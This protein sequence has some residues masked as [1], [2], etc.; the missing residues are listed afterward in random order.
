MILTRDGI[1]YRIA[2][3]LPEGG[4][5]CVSDDATT[6]LRARLP[7][8]EL[9]EVRIYSDFTPEVE[10]FANLRA[11]LDNYQ[12]PAAQL[13]QPSGATMFYQL[14]GDS[15]GT[16]AH[17]WPLAPGWFKVNL[18]PDELWAG[19]LQGEQLAALLAALPGGNMNEFLFESGGQLYRTYL[20]PW[21]PG[22]DHAA[23][24]Q[25][26]FPA[27]Q[28]TFAGR[29]EL[30]PTA[31]AGETSTG[32]L[33]LVYLAGGD[34]WLL[35][36]GGVALQLTLS[37]DVGKVW[38]SPDGQSVIYSLY[39]P[40]GSTELWATDPASSQ[41]NLLAGGPDLA[42]DLQFLALSDVGSLLAFNRFL[43][44]YNAEL[45][46]AA[47]DGSGA[48]Q[49]VSLEDL[50]GIL[51]E[52]EL[53]EPLGV[54]PAGVTWVPGTTTLTYDAYPIFD[55][56]YIYIQKQVWV[57]DAASGA[58]AEMFP[59]GEG[60]QVSYSPDGRQLALTTPERLSVMNVEGRL[61][62]EPDLPY[63][64]VGM[65]EYYFSPQPVWAADSSRF[66]LAV[67]QGD[68]L[69]GSTDIWQVA[70][71]GDATA[72]LG[73]FS[74]FVASFNF[75]PDLKRVAFWQGSDQSLIQELH[76]AT[77][78]GSEEQVY[79]QAEQVDFLGW[80]PDAQHFVYTSG[81]Q[82]GATRTF[83]GDTCGSPAELEVGLQWLTWLADNRY[84]IL[85]GGEQG[86]L[87]LGDLSGAR[88]LLVGAASP[89]EDF[90]Q[91]LLPAP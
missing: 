67:P 5:L 2:R 12:H 31:A 59:P 9:R 81:I 46:V 7:G 50:L 76:L 10:V 34:A 16:D 19:V 78:D 14:A 26:A 42:G 66:L 32:R 83:L 91:V 49:L 79:A 33:R 75:S 80:A 4:S 72:R 87:Y 71:E 74:G 29:P 68:Q 52:L 62:Q 77:V 28:E 56:I 47:M 20:V 3:D 17:A 30:C 40:D 88:T 23:A 63:Q 73:Q 45:W 54:V 21:L 65:G 41:A 64:S 43:D 48:R 38:L 22:V 8:G 27:A 1:A 90:D 15:Q 6:I 44:D 18:A 61:R 82:P 86:G 69:F 35:D 58:Q 84:L 55:A 51:G 89:I 37:G 57:V 53:P 36:E 39:N 11:F 60:G 70:A 24:I 25:A 85:A 13:Y